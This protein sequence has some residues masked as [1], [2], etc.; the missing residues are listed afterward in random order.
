MKDNLFEVLMGVLAMAIVGGAVTLVWGVI[1]IA[2][3]LMR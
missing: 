1:R 3:Y 2:D